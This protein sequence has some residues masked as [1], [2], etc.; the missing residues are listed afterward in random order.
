MPITADDVIAPGD[1][2]NAKIATL[3]DR[4]VVVI[5]ELSTDWTRAEYDMALARARSED[6]QLQ[7]TRIIVIVR[8][9]IDVPNLASGV[10]YVRRPDVLSEEQ[11]SFSE[12]LESILRKIAE[13]IGILASCKRS[14]DC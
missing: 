9:D 8:D 1:S 14:V 3:I 6:G 4:S 13:E 12:V 10:H 2:V 5:V 7:K 11:D